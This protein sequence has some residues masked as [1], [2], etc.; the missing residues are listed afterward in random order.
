MKTGTRTYVQHIDC[1][2][3]QHLVNQGITFCFEG[4]VTQCDK[5]PH[6]EPRDVS[7]TESWASTSDYLTYVDAETG[8]MKEMNILIE[9]VQD[10]KTD[11]EEV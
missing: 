6:K 3:K 11:P 5:C 8:E 10:N 1:I 7:V 4:D 9:D 2:H